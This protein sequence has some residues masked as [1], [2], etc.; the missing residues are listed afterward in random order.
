MFLVAVLIKSAYKS[1]PEKFRFRYSDTIPVV[2][3]P[4]NGSNTRPTGSLAKLII[5]ST[6]FSGNIAKCSLP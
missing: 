5:F 6:N 3:Q 4:I 2:P 1:T